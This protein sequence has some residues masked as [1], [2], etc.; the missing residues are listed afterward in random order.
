MFFSDS[1]A[2]NW[3][4]YFPLPK[5]PNFKWF[6]AIQLGFEEFGHNIR[7]TTGT[8]VCART[9]RNSQD[10]GLTLHQANGESMD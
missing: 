7:P 5:M 1:F 10:V 8:Y 3:N 4:A 2:F 6:F 9:V